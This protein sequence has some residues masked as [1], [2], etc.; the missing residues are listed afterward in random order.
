MEKTSSSVFDRLAPFIQEYI[1]RKGW[2]ELR[3]VQVEAARTLFETD[4]HLLLASGTASLSSLLCHMFP[5][6]I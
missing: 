1:Y 2:S 3:E 4:H 6:Y 5:S